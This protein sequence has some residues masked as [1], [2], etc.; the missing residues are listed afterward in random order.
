MNMKRLLSFTLSVLF[1]F[2]TF[3]IPITANAND[4]DSSENLKTHTNSYVAY[5]DS[6]C[7]ITLNAYVE[8][9]A[10][11]DTQSIIPSCDVVLV[12]DQAKTMNKNR[13]YVIE[14]A[15]NLVKNLPE[16]T[17]GKGGHKV[18]IL[19][20]GRLNNPAEGDSFD[21]STYAGTIRKGVCYN[22]GIYSYDKTTDKVSFHSGSGTYGT[23][24]NKF[25]NEADGADTDY[26]TFSNDGSGDTVDSN[27]NITTAGNMPTLTWGSTDVAN[28]GYSD[29]F[30][31]QD[32]AQHVLTEANMNMF[33]S[34]G[35][36]MDAGMELLNQILKIR[37]SATTT[38][39][40][41]SGNEQ[42]KNCNERPLFVLLISGTSPTQHGSSGNTYTSRS[43]SVLKGAQLVKELG[44][45]FY[46]LGDFEGSLESENIWENGDAYNSLM[47][48]IAA[49][50]S[51]YVSIANTT[52]VERARR[53]EQMINL[54][55]S[56]VTNSANQIVT[57]T[58]MTTVSQSIDYDI[59]ALEKLYT[60]DYDNA[61]FYTQAFKDYEASTATFHSLKQNEKTV[62]VS[63]STDDDN[64]TT[65][66]YLI[67]SIVTIPSE[68]YYSNTLYP[69]GERVTIQITGT[70]KSDNS[71]VVITTL[72]DK[73]SNLGTITV[74]TNLD[75]SNSTT[76]T[77]DGTGIFKSES[78]LPSGS[79]YI[80][81]DGKIVNDA[82]YNPITVTPGDVKSVKY[83]T[84][85]F[86]NKDGSVYNDKQ[87]D[88]DETNGK[89][90]ITGT[91]VSNPESYTTWYNSKYYHSTSTKNN[92]DTAIT[93]KTELYADNS[94]TFNYYHTFKYTQP[95]TI[96]EYATLIYNGEAVDPTKI[97]GYT[98][99]KMNYTPATTTSTTPTVDD[100]K[101][102]A[103]TTKYN[104]KSE[105]DILTNNA[106][107]KKRVGVSYSLDNISSMKSKIW[108][109]FEFKYE[110]VTYTSSV[111]DRN[112]YDMIKKYLV[113][114][115]LSTTHKTD[116]DAL[117]NS[118]IDL[119]DKFDAAGIGYNSD[120]VDAVEI[121][122][123]KSEIA[124]VTATTGTYTLT[125]TLSSRNY[126]PW[127]IKG[128]CS[129]TDS[130]SNNVAYNSFPDYGMI[131]C[132]G[133]ITSVN[134]LLKNK[135][136]MVYSSADG[137][138][139]Q[140]STNAN[141][142]CAYYVGYLT[143]LEL[144]DDISFAF[145]IKDTNGD[146]HFSNITTT[147]YSTLADNDSSWN[148]DL[149]TAINTYAQEVANYNKAH[150]A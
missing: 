140:D 39:T 106:G 57:S 22:T 31:S 45:L 79:Y 61:T 81:K 19:G 52:A 84:V 65:I 80:F 116:Q 128:T 25:P 145:Y 137:N 71:L 109:V 7:A 59:T 150:G 70:R 29:C 10:K 120:Y 105:D 32:D 58:V 129:I 94:F 54:I 77:E 110:G 67:P 107:G 46:T 20:Y 85:D 37:D 47:Q 56:G 35:S 119:S 69:Y 131:V 28:P 40:D 11:F 96:G 100:V 104:E 6:S 43:G 83:Y 95:F 16:A 124:N 23:S 117:I 127:G 92:F 41:D 76:L 75:G 17:D 21:T 91:V 147:S 48:Q 143:T 4:G 114:T 98:I 97:D 51:Y 144:S 149:K 74:S 49:S 34:G 112:F 42:T 89:Y 1:T 3:I 27:G 33:N 5:D 2:S 142:F 38:Y 99:Y 86:Y 111:K 130:N 102:N 87:Y 136:A 9:A 90:V 30:M 146:Y 18:S 134:D 101:N 13:T 73:T 115:D 123:S 135:D 133:T 66:E 148:S 88:Y 82:D 24:K 122:N 132:K 93:S 68:D 126:D 15:N 118:M 55:N 63:K 12:F 50:P 53:L 113:D 8:N 78:T 36:R 121:A 125:S 103:F 62:S 14:A 72:N 64:I 44:G 139:Y 26:F 60:F 108:F 141:D 138:I